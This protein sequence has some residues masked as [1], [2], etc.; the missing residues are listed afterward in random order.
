MIDNRDDPFNLIRRARIAEIEKRLYE[1]E[2]YS[3]GR[4]LALKDHLELWEKKTKL[5]PK[6][7]TRVEGLD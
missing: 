5:L 7:P 2:E 4:F 3:R 6:P 1:I